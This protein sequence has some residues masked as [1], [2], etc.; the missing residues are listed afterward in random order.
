MLKIGGCLIL[1]VIALSF[2]VKVLMAQSETMPENDSIID[3]STVSCRDLL[4]LDDED[5]NST[6]LFFHGYM[7]G[8]KGDLNADVD[9][10]AEISSQ[11]IDYC[12][13]NPD[14]TLMSVFNRYRG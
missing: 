5:K 13:D 1:T 6:I 12:I 11:V 9:A 4:K 2:N 10:L 3:L 7:S 8:K 14:D